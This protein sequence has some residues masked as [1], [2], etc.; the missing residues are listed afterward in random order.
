MRGK[1][2]APSGRKNRAA[3]SAEREVP[4]TVK[5]KKK[6][7]GTPNRSCELTVHLQSDRLMEALAPKYPRFGF[8]K[9]KGYGTAAHLQSL[10]LFG[11]TPEHRKSFLKK[12]RPDEFSGIAEQGTLF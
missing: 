3:P 9:H 11:P 2:E 5:F 1:R 4:F 7:T 8:E 12:L 10:M 6:L